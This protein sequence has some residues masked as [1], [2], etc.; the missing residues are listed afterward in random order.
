M[1]AIYI[2]LSFCMG[3][4]LGNLLFEKDPVMLKPPSQASPVVEKIQTI[5]TLKLKAEGELRRQNNFLRGQLV[6]TDL[7]LKENRG[8][9]GLERKKVSRLQARLLE[10]SLPGNPVADTLSERIDTLNA[11]T[12]SLFR[13]Y[14]TKINLTESSLAVRDSEIVI[15]NQAYGQLK[16]LAKEQAYREQQLTENLNAVLKEQ[17]KK[18]FQNRLLVGGMVFLSGIA[19]TL[20]IQQKQ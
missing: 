4:F 18:R 13:D 7:Q 5:D 8:R 1:K 20:L 15:C 17:K 16:D 12:D 19:A 2:I 14:E 9:L 10:D 3:L 11:I 6:I